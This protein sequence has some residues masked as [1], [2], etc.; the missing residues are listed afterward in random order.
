[1]VDELVAIRTRKPGD[2]L[3]RRGDCPIL[4]WGLNEN[5]IDYSAALKEPIAVYETPLPWLQSGGR[6]ICIIDW[7]LD[8]RHKLA[9]LKFACQ[10]TKLED[11]LKQRVCKAALA[12][13]DFAPTLED[14]RRAA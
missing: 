10:T 8:P 1:M 13:F 7:E 4:G 9:G 11:D 3:V 5:L 6:G 14:T 12:K 2:W